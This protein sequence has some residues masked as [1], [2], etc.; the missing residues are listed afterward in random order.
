LFAEAVAIFIT[1]LIIK[2]RFRDS[3]RND[4]RDGELW[5]GIGA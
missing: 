1:S 2:A 5:C 4:R 3:W